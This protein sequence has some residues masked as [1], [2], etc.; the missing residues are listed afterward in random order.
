VPALTASIAAAA[1]SNL[2]EA[3]M[4]RA[5]SGSIRFWHR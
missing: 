1:A 5:P 2:I 4:V 3:C